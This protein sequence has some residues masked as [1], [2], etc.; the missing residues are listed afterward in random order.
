[1][2][3]DAILSDEEVDNL[4][5]APG[6]S[7]AA[8]VSDISGRGVGMD[9]VKQNITALRGVIEINSV[10]GEGATIKIYLPLTLAIIDGFL[11]TIGSSFFVIPQ[12]RII[13][14]IEM[15]H[16]NVNSNYM[17]L[18]G[19]VLPLIRLASFFNIQCE[20]FKRE[21]VVVVNSGGSKTGLV[22][23]RLLGEYQTVIKPLGKLFTHV[24]GIGGSTILGGGEV[25]L[26]VDVQVLVQYYAHREY[27]AQKSI[28]HFAGAQLV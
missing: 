15:P 27:Q 17:D 26:I 20:P 21:N 3:P 12:D 8:A 25:A 4:I 1:V 14:C 10:M 13:E 11:V 24:Q 23:D 5:F 6:F 22:V 2:E 19:E 7:T 16:E 28:P 18:R 9:V